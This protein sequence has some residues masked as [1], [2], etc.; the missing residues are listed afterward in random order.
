MIAENSKW[1]QF[2]KELSNLFF[3][4][5]FG[6]IF[7][8]LFRIIF[9]LLFKE[10]ISSNVGFFE[11]GSVLFMGFRFDSTAV[12]YFMVLPLFL[13]L[14][15]A[16]FNQFRIIK[17]TRKIFQYLFVILSVLICII[18]LNY[19]SEYKDQFNNFLFLAIYDDQK[20]ALSTVLK[21]FHPIL[22]SLALILL[23]FLGIFILRKFESK[24]RV[25]TFFRKIESLKYKIFLVIFSL[26]LFI[27]GIRGTFAAVPASQKIAGISQDLF[28]NKTIINPYRSLM[29]AIEAFKELNLLTDVN[30]F[31]DNKSF[32]KEYPQKKVTD[33]IKK[34]SQGSTIEKPK[35]IFIVVMESYDSWPLMDKYQDFGVSKNLYNIAKTGTHF[36]QFLPCTGA[37]FDSFGSVVTSIPYCGVNVGQ[38]GN[39]NQT[40][41][42]SLFTQFKKLG[43]ETNLF[44]GGLPSWQNLGDFVKHQGIDNIYTGPNTGKQMGEWGVE[45]EELF[46][47]VLKNTD[48][49]KNS[50]NIILTVS[51]HPPFSI[52]IYKKGFPYKTEKDMPMSAQK[53]F[54]GAMRL[55]ELGHLW[56]GDKA[57]GDFVIRSEKKY[58]NALFCFTGDHFGRRFVNHSPNLYERSSVPFI[59]YGNGVPAQKNQTPGSHIDITPTLIEM[60]APKGFE[61]YSFGTNLFD[62]NKKV[63]FGHG[64]M[65]IPNNFYTFNGDGKMETIN[66]LTNKEQLIKTDTKL[67]Y[68]YNHYMSLAWHYII[69]GNSL[70][71][72]TKK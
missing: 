12:C 8:T 37:T 21:D 54:D 3:F 28:L 63:G 32:H 49:T 11:I 43:Y 2:T 24:T 62:K 60:I 35:Q 19:F 23:I 27:S 55:V 70:E 1:N 16:P 9:I 18:T 15:L 57:I 46:E 59:I 50:L 52:D 51:Y 4:W 31:L 22:N 25:F 45:D 7:F 33:V 39:V 40:L 58:N 65:V 68:Q 41:E 48:T 71:I 13:L 67:E 29:Y 61:Y 6:I 34:I 66:T 36:T 56:Y 20:A 5:F 17:I 30:P 53:K 69:K 42:T 10:N 47:M 38:L 64:K 44:Y 72:K 14:L 26:F